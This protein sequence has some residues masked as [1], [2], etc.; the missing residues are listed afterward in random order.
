MDIQEILEV[1]ADTLDKAIPT[2]LRA[3]LKDKNYRKEL[4]KLVGRTAFLDPDNL[5]F[6]VKDENGKHVC[7]LIYAAYLRAKMNIGRSNRK[8]QVPDSFYQSI[9]N[10]AQILFKSTN[11]DE[12]MRIN[13][14]EDDSENYVDFFGLFD[15]SQISNTELFE[16]IENSD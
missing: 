14:H 12:S 10:K 8:N 1:T 13:L 11:C 15:L 7:Q 9:A 3:K 2:E 16:Y 4:L 6:P 5:K